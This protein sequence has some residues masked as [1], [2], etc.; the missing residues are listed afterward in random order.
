M[1]PRRRLK[2]REGD[3]FSIP[4]DDEA[5]V[6]YGQIVAS[7]GEG[8]FYFAVFD[9]VYPADR[10]IDLERHVAGPLL[11]LALSLDALLFHGHWQV[12]GHVEVDEERIPWPAYKEGVLPPGAFEVVD[13]RDRRRRMASAE[14]VERL[15]FRKVVAPIRVEK[16]LR[17]LIGNEP[18]DNDYETLRP[19]DDDLTSSA[20]LSS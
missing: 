3:V 9:G 13:A 16:A 10:E 19:V 14:E 2:L 1:S 12:V 15:P 7:W 20:L 8:H 17:A 11:L 18:W 4:V 5:R 6:G